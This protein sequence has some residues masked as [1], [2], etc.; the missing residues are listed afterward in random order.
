MTIGEE[1]DLNV[2]FPDQYH[3]ADLAGKP[4]VFAVKLLGI[5][6]KVLPELND[7]FAAD[8]TEFSTLEELKSDIKKHALEHKEHHAKLDAENELIGKVV[9]NA[10][11]EV[12]ESMVN[13]QLDRMI[14]DVRQR[15]AYQ[16]LSFEQYLEYTGST[17]DAYKESRRAEAKEGVKT[18]LV[19]EEIV[20]KENIQVTEEDIDAK[21]E[22]L[23]KQMGK[24]AEELKK[25]VLKGQED[26]LKNT[27]LSEKVIKV[28]KE[29][30]N[31]V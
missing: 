8:T 11:V 1:K 6:E 20:K 12:P 28:L 31:I 19:L 4:A 15:L 14:N 18:T 5:R 30:N 3:S 25:T 9:K 7:E 24:T 2:K 26:Y 27:I 10:E 16:G 13:Q 23:G 17:L 29:L 22:E 21:L